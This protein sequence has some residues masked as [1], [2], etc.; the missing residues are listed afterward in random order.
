A[1]QAFRVPLEEVTP[2]LRRS[3]KAV[4]FGIVYGMSDF[5][6]AVDLHITRRQA[7]DY[8]DSYFATYPG[9]RRYLDEVVKE[10]R[11]RGYVKTLLGRRRYLPELTSKNFNQRSFGE[12]AAMNT[13]IQGTAADII[14]L[15]MVRVRNRLLREG[16]K[17][18]LVLQVHDELIVEAPEAEADAATA[19]LEQEMM[20]AMELSVPLT[21]EVKRGKSWLEA[22]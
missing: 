14:K 2:E 22:H 4:N 1:S 16:L 21:V 5:S 13:P 20:G 15:A 12:R 10:A 17:A 18:R 11:E 7:K 6:L 8:I 9:I 19:I 3:A